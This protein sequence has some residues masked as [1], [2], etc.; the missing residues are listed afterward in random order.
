MIQD[1][2]IVS[3][4]CVLPP[5]KNASPCLTFYFSNNFVKNQPIVINFGKQLPEETSRVSIRFINIFGQ[6][7]GRGRPCKHFPHI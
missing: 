3:I 2:Q 7:R 4:Q 6:G 1:A 5:T